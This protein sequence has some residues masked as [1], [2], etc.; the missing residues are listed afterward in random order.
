MFPRTVFYIRFIKTHVVV[1][2]YERND[3]KI[4]WYHTRIRSVFLIKEQFCK[5]YKI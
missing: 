2:L 1:I 4:K 3:K 5:W